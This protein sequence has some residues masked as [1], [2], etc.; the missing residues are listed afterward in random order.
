[1]RESYHVGIYDSIIP[2]NRYGS[3]IK[4]YVCFKDSQFTLAVVVV[5]Q[6][7]IIYWQFIFGQ[8]KS[9]PPPAATLI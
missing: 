5:Q 7:F 9:L 8:Q 4:N 1:M 6:S 3:V 2:K